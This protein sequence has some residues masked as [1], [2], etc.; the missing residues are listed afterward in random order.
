MEQAE[1]DGI[2]KERRPF[3]GR[4]IPRNVDEYGTMPV[5]LEVLQASSTPLTARQ[6]VERAGARLPT[7]A[8]NEPGRPYKRNVVARDLARELARGEASR[9]RKVRRGLFEA[10]R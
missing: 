8:V 10:V 6:I 3:G 4:V 1:Q 2:E 9:V 5:V 7:K